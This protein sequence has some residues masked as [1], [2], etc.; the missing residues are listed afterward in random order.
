MSK[1]KQ[2]LK[3]KFFH[4]ASLIYLI[5]YYLTLRYSASKPLALASLSIILMAFLIME[6]FRIIK[7][8]KI[9]IF[10]N[11]WR[12]EENQKLGGEIYYLFGIILAL[13]FFDFKIALTSI[14]MMALG[15]SVATLIGIKFGK[16]KLVKN[17]SIQGTSAGLIMNIIV[18]YLILGN[19]KLSIPMAIA[20]TLVEIF[21]QKIDD[22]LTIPVIAG[23]V[24]QLI[25]FRF[26]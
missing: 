19:W 7:K 2:E 8:K 18:S 5:P 1:F 25:K 21:S 9:P 10:N 14:L 12:P 3:R 11:I 17:S 24:G 15:D 20:A 13:T 4:V 6:Y 22:N 23:L 26:F 16:N